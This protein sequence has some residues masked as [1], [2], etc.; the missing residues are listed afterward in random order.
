M[1]SR[2][3]DATLSAPGPKAEAAVES[4]TSIDDMIAVERLQG[5]IWGSDPTWVVPS[6][7]LYIVADYG[8]ILLG[9]RVGGELVGF[10]F[11]LLARQDSKLLHASHMLGILPAYQGHGIGVALKHQQRLKAI[12][13]GL[14]LMTWTFDPLEARNAHFNLHKLG[15]VSRIYRANYYG[16]MRDALNEGLPSDRLVTEWS[17]RNGRAGGAYHGP[18]VP[19]LDDLAGRPELNLDP[20]TL[21]GPVSVCVPQ[22][23]QGLRR[24]DPDA[25]LA[26]RLAVRQAFTWAFDHGFVAKDFRDGAHILVPAGGGS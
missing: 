7:M 1:H 23:F 19:M 2:T 3:P 25:A 8:G 20:S 21:A 16:P 11:G 24:D 14:D 13:Q 26:W 15:A 18:I 5:V 6:H 22:D 4:L 17:L 12:G 9:A 10:V